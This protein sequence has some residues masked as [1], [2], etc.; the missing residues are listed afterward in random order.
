MDRVGCDCCYW[1]LW[2]L[3][4]RQL[5]TDSWVRKLRES[6]HARRQLGLGLPLAAGSGAAATVQGAGKPWVQTLPAGGRPDRADKR[7]VD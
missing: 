5:H 4:H 2:Q 3:N 1:L 7:E 6:Y